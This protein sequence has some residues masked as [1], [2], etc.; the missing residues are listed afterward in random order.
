MCDSFNQVLVLPACSFHVALG[1]ADYFKETLE[2][3][4]HNTAI[5]RRTVSHFMIQ[6]VQDYMD[7][8]STNSS[9][10]NEES[11][12]KEVTQHY[13]YKN[14]RNVPELCMLTGR[15]HDWHDLAAGHIVPRARAAQARVDVNIWE[16][17]NARNGIYWSRA[18]EGA[19]SAG[20]FCFASPGEIPRTCT[21]HHLSRQVQVVIIVSAMV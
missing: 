15:E 7:P 6:R 10:P 20:I 16:I 13:G 14:A 5:T 9:N 12:R 2:E 1:G 4:R 17:N 3:I 21:K 11:F 19:W 8:G 18:V